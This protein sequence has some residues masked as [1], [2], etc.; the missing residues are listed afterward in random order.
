MHLAAHSLGL[1]SL[2]FTL[3]DKKAMREILG[4]LPE[5]TPLAMICLGKA[6]SPPAPTPRKDL[7]EKTVY[8]R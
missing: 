2:W 5:K 4:I 7:K 1:G 8:I 6:D 3:F